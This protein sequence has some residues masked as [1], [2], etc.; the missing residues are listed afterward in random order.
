MP[1]SDKVSAVFQNGAC[2][3]DS[4]VLFFYFSQLDGL[5]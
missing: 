5:Y 2:E 4:D 1:L 3:T